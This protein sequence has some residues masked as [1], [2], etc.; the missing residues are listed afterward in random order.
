MRQLLAALAIV[1][2][3][4]STSFAAVQATFAWNASAGADHYTLHMVDPSGTDSVIADNVVA[5]T[6]QITHVVT[7]QGE[8]SF[9]VTATNAFGT[10]GPSNVVVTN[11]GNE[12]EPPANFSVK[13][14]FTGI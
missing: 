10:S 9:Y 11:L 2:L 4:A 8:Y 6:T 12:P 5:E 7:E 13:V 1:V 3:I 14:V